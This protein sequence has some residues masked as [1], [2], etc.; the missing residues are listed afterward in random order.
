MAV[1]ELRISD[2]SSDVCTADLSRIAIGWLIV[3][4]IFMILALLLLPTLADTLGGRPSV[5]A[6]GNLLQDIALTVV[7]V[8]AFAGLALVVGKRVIPWLLAKVD[9][10]GSRESSEERR[11][12]KGCVSTGR[13]RWSLSP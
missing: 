10:T 12:G 5:Y 8:A 11:V 2:W 6:G 1:Y 9:A 13:S 4:D 3:E 7:K